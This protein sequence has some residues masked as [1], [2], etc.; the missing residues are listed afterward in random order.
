MQQMS[1]LQINQ[2]MSEKA[3]IENILKP[4]YKRIGWTDFYDH[5]RTVQSDWIGP[6]ENCI[7]YIEVLNLSG[8]SGA[9]IDALKAEGFKIRASGLDVYIIND[10]NDNK[11]GKENEK[12]NHLRTLVIMELDATEQSEKPNVYNM[13]NNPA[14]K[15]EIIKYVIEKVIGEARSISGAIVAIEREYN[16]NLQN[17]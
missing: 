11:M 4:F 10:K 2:A 14:T 17:D 15:E 6:I 9:V 3:N 12:L 5:P 8:G 13:Y 16:I 7:A 1:S